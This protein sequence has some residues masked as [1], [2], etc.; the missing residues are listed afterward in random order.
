MPGPAVI[1]NDKDLREPIRRISY[2][3]STRRNLQSIGQPGAINQVMSRSLPCGVIA[4]IWNA[5][6]LKITLPAMSV[7]PV[8]YE[9]AAG[10]CDDQ[11]IRLQ[12]ACA[13]N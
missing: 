1:R 7:P 3:N 4:V 12:Q 11:H 8:W 6:V 2:P 10:I 13:P 9:L 5:F